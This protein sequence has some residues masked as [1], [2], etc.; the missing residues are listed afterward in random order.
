MAK[1]ERFSPKHLQKRKQ[2][3]LLFKYFKHCIDIVLMQ[4]LD[5]VSKVVLDGSQLSCWILLGLAPSMKL[6]ESIWKLLNIIYSPSENSLLYY[7]IVVFP[8]P[9]GIYRFHE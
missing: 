5:A 4:N 3:A 7:Y 9:G 8:P 2:S 6:C 1:F